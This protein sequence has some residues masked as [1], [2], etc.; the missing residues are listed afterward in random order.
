MAQQTETKRDFSTR[1]SPRTL[2]QLDELVQ[3]GRFKTRTEA[4]EAAVTSVYDAEQ[5][6]QQELQEAFDRACGALSL[7]IDREAWEQAELDRLEW[8]VSRNTGDRASPIR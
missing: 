2:R 8:E 5:R 3:R 6:E 7:G 1:L 4:I